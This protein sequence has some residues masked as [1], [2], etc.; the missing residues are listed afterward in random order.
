MEPNQTSAASRTN[1]LG[2]RIDPS[3]HIRF[4]HLT[5]EEGLSVTGVVDILQDQTGFMWFATEDG[6]NKYDGYTFEVYRHDPEEP[7]SLTDSII[8]ELYEDKAGN[9]WIGTYSGGLNRFDP[10]REQFTHYRNNPDDPNSLSDNQV[11]DLLEDHSGAVWIGTANGL[12]RLD[13]NGESWRRYQNDPDDPTSLSADYVVSIYEDSNGNLWVGTTEGLD[14]F[15][16]ETEQ[17]I[18]F[19]NNPADPNSLSGTLVQTIFEDRSG[20]LWIGTYD[21]G[22]N[23]FD[24][25]NETFIRYPYDPG[26]PNSLSSENVKSI[27]EDTWGDLWIGTDG[28]LNRFDRE[29]EI[30]IHYQTNP[31]DPY[32][33]SHND[34]ECIYEDR[35]GGLWIG[36]AYGGVNH[37][38]RLSEQFSLYQMD[39]ND[40]NSL[41]LN[42]IWSIWENPAGVLWIGT[43]GGGLNRFDREK[44]VWT[45][46]QSEPEN[47]NS[48]SNDIVMDVYEDQTGTV[49]IGT[50]GGGL[51]RLNPK[52]GRFTHYRS[53]PE[54][55]RSL[56]SDAVWLVY[57]DHVGA[58]WVGTSN[59]LNRFDRETGQFT[60][61]LHNPEDATSISDSTIGSIYEDRSGTLW[62]GTF[63]GLDRFDRDTESF[64][65]YFHDP[66]DIQTLSHDIVFTIHEDSAGILFVGTFGGGLNR[67]DRE[68]GSFTHY[69]V[70]DGLSNDVVYGILEDDQGHLW[71]STNNGLSRFDPVL[72]TFR[73]FDVRDG[74]QAR[75][76]NYN[77]YFKSSSGEMFFG[78]VGGL[79]AFHPERIVDNPYVP[80]IVLKTIS[81]GGE[82]MVLDKA[83]EYITDV[84]LQWPSNYFDFEFVALNFFQPEQ[85][86][87]AYKLEGFDEDWNDIGTRRFGRYTNLPGGTYTLRLKGSNNDGVWND[88]GASL[89][90]TV[91]PPLW[92]TWL[93]R[94]IFLIV[95]VGGLIVGYQW[96]VR[97]IEARSRELKF[98]VESRTKELASLN[99]IASTV[100]QSLELDSMLNATLDKLLQVLDLDT[101]AIYVIDQSTKELQEV[102]HRNPSKMFDHLF[103]DEGFTVDVAQTGDPIIDNDLSLEPDEHRELLE[104]G[105]LSSATIPL[106]SKGQV[107]GVLITASRRVD[108]FQKRDVDLLLSIGSQIGV[109]I[110]N[111]QLHEATKSRV[112]QLTT[113]QDTT[114][115]LASTLE[116]EKLLNLIIQ[117]ATA[118]LQAD[119]G[120]IN[121]VDWEKKEDEVVAATGSA[122]FTPGS[123]SHLEGSLSGWVALHNQPV[124][125]NQI[126]DDDRVAKHALSW[127]LEAGIQSAAV[128]PLTIKDQ[129][130]GTLVLMG[131]K[132]GKR[133]FDPTDLDLLV[134]FANQAAIAIEN[135]QL[136]EQAQQLA[137]VE[138]RQRLARDLHDSVTQALYGMTLYSE[139]IARQLSMGQVDLAKAQ[140]SELHDTAQ[141]ALREMRLL[142]FQ[143]RPPDLEEEGLVAILRNR[144]EAVEGRADL[145]T[146]FRVPNEAR[147]P[148]E[149]EE[150]LYRISQETLNNS[151]KHASAQSVTV[152]L[153]IDES[154]VILEIIDDGIGFD[155]D[156]ALEGSGMGLKGMM[157]RAA[158]MGGQLTVESRPGA[159]TKVRVEVPR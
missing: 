153:L 149:I 36:T 69:T 156:Y 51:N 94:G 71:L 89:R 64:S 157:E 44:G 81:Q 39:P 53:N 37:Y 7:N 145:K 152:S 56:S 98:Q 22:L 45:H 63:N 88:G 120:M 113:L 10:I 92:E 61:F 27:D 147:L 107:L 117:Q 59:G 102:C 144:L 19:S 43:N 130:I 134:S 50:W 122:A 16:T 23:Q 74:L 48:L 6:L 35:S 150:G 123:R 13:L 93:F 99:D 105:L 47:P 79:N 115:A 12:N 106:T 135:A 109:A 52:T 80:P 95:V 104:G 103:R 77:A 32:S 133:E 158:Q 25:Q 1:L 142:I 65:H 110:E 73:N 62:V 129:V 141:E 137:V 146:E 26:N 118:L 155:P 38:D 91:V 75:E 21:G 127:V 96:R 49:W 3:R 18:H 85:N 15:E 121:L 119:G 68:S 33:L 20:Q 132:E 138:E 8:V 76:F 86:L 126:P 58:L 114:R 55:P 143:L 87:Y 131:T 151:L 41:S 84:T 17:F 34:V 125:S 112:A 111:A 82:L 72:E 40:P 57:E 11:T 31:D 124:I 70:K 60:R 154:L 159:G 101:G 4:E 54:D 128:A 139:A 5:I 30:F 83:F 67:F 2:Y 97:S 100:S 136:Y 42:S 29:E 28:G 116:L 140:L 46:Y 24:R 14:R 108:G 148:L 78:G 9:L 66:D 90:I